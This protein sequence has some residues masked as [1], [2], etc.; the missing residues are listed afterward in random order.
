MR[1][2]TSVLVLMLVLLMIPLMLLPLVTAKPTVT[3][4]IKIV[5]Q[6]VVE[7]K[8]TFEESAYLLANYKFYGKVKHA[9]KVYWVFEAS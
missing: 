1:F 6:V 8:P 2:K 7:H 4:D 9:G 3:V 5:K